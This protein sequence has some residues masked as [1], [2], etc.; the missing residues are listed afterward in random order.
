MTDA[1]ELMRNPHVA[2]Q[3][4][5]PEPNL[6]EQMMRNPHLRMT[7]EDRV[8]M[9]RMLQGHGVADLSHGQPPGPN[10][11]EQMMTQGH[12]GGPNLR[13]QMMRNMPPQRP[14]PPLSYNGQLPGIAT[15]QPFGTRQHL[16]P[17]GQVQRLEPYQTPGWPGTAPHE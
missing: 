7:D 14:L 12:G 10:V 16:R 2:S 13:E 15:V 11:L 4:S 6:R 8:K 17:D 5:Q 1:N 3:Y 9:G